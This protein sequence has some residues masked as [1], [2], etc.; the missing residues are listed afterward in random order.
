VNCNY[1]IPNVIGRQACSFV[2][3][4]RMGYAASGTPVAV[5]RKAVEPVN[6]VRIF[7]VLTNGEKLAAECYMCSFVN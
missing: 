6:E 5:K 2:G 3:K 1:F 4:I 7:Y